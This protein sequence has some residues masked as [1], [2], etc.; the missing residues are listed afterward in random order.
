MLE[1]SPVVNAAPAIGLVLR[2]GQTDPHY[3]RVTHIF[4]ACIYFMTI[5]G[6]EQ[7][8]YARRPSR[9]SSLAMQKLLDAD[10]TWGR[11]VLPASLSVA[12]SPDS[13]RDQEIQAAWALIAPL[14]EAFDREENL[15]RRHFSAL[16]RERANATGSSIST[17]RRT[18]LRYYYFGR[19]RLALPDLPPGTKPGT[20]AYTSNKSNN[21]DQE[22]PKRRGRKSILADEI[23]ANNFVV[24]EHDINDMV[25]CL[26]NKRKQGPTSIAAA[27]EHYLAHEFRHRHPDIQAQYLSHKHL[28]PVSQR[29]FRY[30]VNN[31]ARMNADLAAN[32]PLRPRNPGHLGSL[33]AAGPGEVYEIDSTGGRLYLVAKDEDGKPVL[34]GKP[35]IYLIVDRWSR[36]I[37]SAYLSLRSASYEEVRHT[38]L[39]AFTSRERRFTTIGVAVDDIQWPVGRMPAVLCPD[40]GSDFMSDSMEQAVVSDLL[41]ELTPL[42]PYCPD[43]KA[44]VERLIR[45][46]KRR[47]AQS[48]LKGTYA[49]RPLDPETKRAARKAEAAAIHSVAEA[50]R[51]LI[52]IVVDHNSRPH[53]AL[54]RRRVLTQAGVR[55]IPKDAYLWGLKNITGLRV[56][57]LHEEDY[58]RLLLSSDH[59]SIANGVLRYIKR[60]YL[61]QNEAAIELASKSTS[62]ARKIDIRVDKTNPVEAFVVNRRGTWASFKV[63]Q[64]GESEIVGLTLDEEDAL[65]ARNAVLWARAEHESRLGRVSA[66]SQ[67]RKC[68]SAKRSSPIEVGKKEK[69]SL[70]EKETARLKKHLV[71]N[72]PDT[73]PVC[74]NDKTS[75]ESDWKTYEEQERLRSLDMI[76][77]HRSNR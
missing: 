18:V 62:R 50:Y 31:H 59:A 46:L 27:H 29:Q 60:A 72:K 35:T 45:E 17:V 13:D 32:I 40:R 6:P 2:L 70:R 67:K 11:V 65:S 24:S 75:S 8:R 20:P 54:K 47:M 44:T 37:V 12:P 9:L 53:S 30:Y 16:L 56:P 21:G 57:S 1:F 14:I 39:I 34:V 49:E 51:T 64:G 73:R 4:G 77:K 43:G 69:I 71:A 58:R 41:I 10:A 25:E 23:G 52:E 42:P 63:T 48:E 68:K 55:P 22:Q 36:Y 66:K 19:S 74:E 15:D 7:A 3:M 33:Y 26:K 61:P 38:L 76:R 28:E 5:K